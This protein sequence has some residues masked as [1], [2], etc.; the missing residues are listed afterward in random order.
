MARLSTGETDAF[1]GFSEAALLR[2]RRKLV[3]LSEEI[4]AADAKPDD[5]NGRLATCKRR[6][7]KKLIDGGTDRH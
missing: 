6:E 4:E 1:P 3:K 5:D 7:N 2:L